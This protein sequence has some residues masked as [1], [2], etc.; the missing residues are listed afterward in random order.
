MCFVMTLV[1][2]PYETASAEN[3]TKTVTVDVSFRGSDTLPDDIRTHL[4]YDIK[5]DSELII[6]T[7]M[8]DIE[9]ESACPV[10]LDLTRGGVPYGRICC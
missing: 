5:T 6:R 3:E 8:M 10:V 2:A 7:T 1:I 4:L 9:D